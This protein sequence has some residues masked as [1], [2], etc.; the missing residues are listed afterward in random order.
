[1]ITLALLP[2][3]DNIPMHA[4]AQWRSGLST[5][6][7]QRISLMK[8]NLRQTEFVVTRKLLQTLAQQRLGVSAEVVSAAGTAPTL[9]TADG[10]AIACSISHSN[11]AILVAINTVGPIGVDVEHH[12]PRSVVKVVQRYFWPEGQTY[13]A[14]CSEAKGRA[15]FYRQ[16]GIREALVKY[17]GDG[18][19]FELLG[20]PLSL[21]IGTVGQMSQSNTLTLGVISSG[22]AQPELLYAALDRDSQWTL[23]P[24]S[25]EMGLTA[26]TPIATQ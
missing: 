16:W 22:T 12:R 1:M 23:S 8:G 5:A 19:L 24:L 18:N 3:T 6:D 11:K 15:W 26:L 13:F 7:Q 2:S 21:P 17:Q 9:L 25:T 4:I 20:K 10:R 14:N